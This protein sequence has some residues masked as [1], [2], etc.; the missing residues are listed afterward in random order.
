MTFA[1]FCPFFFSILTSDSQ[2]VAKPSKSFSKHFASV[3][4]L[5]PWE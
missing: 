3:V 2:T 1:F 5:M 4:F